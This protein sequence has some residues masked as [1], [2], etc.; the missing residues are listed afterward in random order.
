MKK[1]FYLGL[2]N[3]ELINHNSIKYESF[4][5]SIR[6][7]YSY[8]DLW[9]KPLDFVFVDFIGEKN[10]K[11]YNLF[12]NEL[13]FVLELPERINNSFESRLYNFFK[14]ELQDVA[15]INVE[16]SIMSDKESIKFKISSYT[17]Y[18]RNAQSS[19]N[20][21]EPIIKLMLNTYA[22]II[23]FLTKEKEKGFKNEQKS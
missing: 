14:T 21:I 13:A 19:E 5:D 11:D 20:I 12:A 7:S 10:G 18:M 6:G 8:N 1:L 9:G 23:L 22:I 3:I 16:Y 4:P 2:K 15:G 17:P